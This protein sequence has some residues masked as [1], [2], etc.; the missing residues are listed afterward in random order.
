MGVLD[1]SI[2]S[3][4][5]KK[6]IGFSDDWKILYIGTQQEGGM[7]QISIEGTYIPVSDKKKIIAYIERKQKE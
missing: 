7:A 3:V 5:Y 6:I 2:L 1:S 4:S